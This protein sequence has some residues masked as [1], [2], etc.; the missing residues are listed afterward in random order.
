MTLVLDGLAI[1]F[2]IGFLVVTV[3]TILFAALCLMAW[4]DRWSA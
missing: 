1:A 3:A 4:L 2:G